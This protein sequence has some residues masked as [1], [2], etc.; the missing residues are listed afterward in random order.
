MWDVPGPRGGAQ[1]REAEGVRWGADPQPPV[2]SS[3]PLCD[4]ACL[5]VQPT[6]L[7][8]P[9]LSLT[10]LVRPMP[11]LSTPSRASQ[12]P[13]TSPVHSV[14]TVQSHRPPHRKETTAGPHPGCPTLCSLCSPEI[15]MRFTLTGSCLEDR[16]PAEAKRRTRKAKGLRPH[17]PHTPPL[18]DTREAYQG[19]AAP[20]RASLVTG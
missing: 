1:P 12:R 2:V 9:G 4:G 11:C 5:R 17:K 19:L 8:S 7:H 20:S 15:W 10:P 14:C 16:R 18:F 13:P 3:P 6:G